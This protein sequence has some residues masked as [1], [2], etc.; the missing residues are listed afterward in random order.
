MIAINPLQ[1]VRPRSRE[2]ADLRCDDAHSAVVPRE[3][4]WVA[5]PEGVA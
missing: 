5:T 2:D 3:A 1:P 4:V